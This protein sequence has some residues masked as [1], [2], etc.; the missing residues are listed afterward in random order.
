MET[1]ES[2]MQK[3]D[4]QKNVLSAHGYIYTQN[5]KFTGLTQ[6]LGQL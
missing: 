1:M 5:L 4:P 2:L 3:S 6:N